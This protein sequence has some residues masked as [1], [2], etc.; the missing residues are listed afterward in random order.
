MKTTVM[1]ILLMKIAN[2]SGGMKIQAM[3]VEGNHKVITTAPL[4]SLHHINK[5]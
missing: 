4:H 3:P 1:K 5:S 2:N